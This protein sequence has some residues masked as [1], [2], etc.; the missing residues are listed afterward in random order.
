VDGWVVA[1]DA[2]ADDIGDIPCPD[3][4]KAFG[5]TSDCE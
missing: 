3:W 4:T 2:W 1:D 5:F